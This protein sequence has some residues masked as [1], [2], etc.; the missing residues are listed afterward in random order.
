MR[1][2]S[3]TIAYLQSWCVNS[4]LIA[5]TRDTRNNNPRPRN[6]RRP[7]NTRNSRK[8]SPRKK[9]NRKFRNR[10]NIDSYNNKQKSNQPKRLNKKQ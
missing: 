4:H 9:S 3:K 5:Y 7:Q 8:S 2:F 6:T 1:K 10:L